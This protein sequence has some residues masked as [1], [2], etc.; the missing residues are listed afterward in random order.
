MIRPVLEKAL[1]SQRPLE[2]YELEEVLQALEAEGGSPARL[3]TGDGDFS[4][5]LS[6]LESQIQSMFRGVSAASAPPGV[7][8]MKSCTLMRSRV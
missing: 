1:I 7:P 6:A 5:R 4:A 8:S 2:D 3:E